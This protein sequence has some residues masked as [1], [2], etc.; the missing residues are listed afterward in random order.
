MRNS[1]V[2]SSIPRPTRLRVLE[3]KRVSVLPGKT[4]VDVLL[5]LF[6]LLEPADLRELSHRNRIFR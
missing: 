6:P 2:S 3:Q 1:S 5:D 4:L